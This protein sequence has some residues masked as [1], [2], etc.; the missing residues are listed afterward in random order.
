VENKLREGGFTQSANDPDTWVHAD[1]SVV[2][3]D[4][5]HRP[6]GPY[7]SQNK[8]HY[9]KSWVDKYGN[10]LKLDD[11]GRVNSSPDRTHIIGR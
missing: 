5:P 10:E 4:P 6:G 9:H 1:G 7:L 3:I 2:R 8:E 11:K